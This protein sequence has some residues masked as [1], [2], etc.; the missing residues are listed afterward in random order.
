MHVRQ[1]RRQFL[2]SLAAGGVMSFAGPVPATLAQIADGG[3]RSG[4]EDV[5]VVIFLRG[6]NDGL[7][8]VIPAGNPLYKRYRKRCRIDASRAIGIDDG[9]SLHPALRNLANVW[10][11]DRLAIIQGVGYPNHN[12]S[13]FVSTAVWHSAKVTARPQSGYGWLGRVLDRLQTTTETPLAY[14][15]G[16]GET[17]H[18]LRGRH[19]RTAAVPAITSAEAREV[20]NLLRGPMV[21][22]TTTH[23]D[24]SLVATRQRDAAAALDQLINSEPLRAGRFPD[25]PLGSRLE[26]VA[27]LLESHN[28]ARV[29]FLEQSN[30]DTHAGQMPTQAELL[31][32]LGD[33]VAAFDQ[34]LEKSGLSKRV[35]TMIFSEFGRRVKENASGGTDHGKAGPVLL[36]GGSVRSGLHG[37]APDLSRLDDGD[38]RVTTDFRGVY[39]SIVHQFSG[40]DDPFAA[41]VSPLSL[42]NLT[43][44]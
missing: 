30:F 6:G 16:L 40:F 34:H 37:S 24:V 13:H 14:S 1:H 9:L 2:S 7:N 25:T 15:S 12:R 26:Q 41:D 38:V 4:S 3:E 10:E 23:A 39:K 18:L 19:T 35:T 20:L 28:P 5:L 42:F 29:Y 33:A 36:M 21:S 43:V 17:P 27:W 8:T 22:T 11:N 44:G 31:R 32:E